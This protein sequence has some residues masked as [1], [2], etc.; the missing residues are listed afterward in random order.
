MGNSALSAEISLAVERLQGTEVSVLSPA[1]YRTASIAGYTLIGISLVLCLFPA[2]LFFALR[3]TKAGAA[4]LDF[5][6]LAYIA[7]LWLSQIG[8]KLA[9]RVP[10]SLMSGTMHVRC[11]NAYGPYLTRDVLVMSY[12]AHDCVVKARHSIGRKRRRLFRMCG[13]YLYCPTIVD[14]VAAPLPTPAKQ[15]AST[16][17][18]ARKTLFVTAVYSGGNRL[19]DAWSQLDW[20]TRTVSEARL[21]E[22]ER[23]TQLW[24]EAVYKFF[25]YERDRQP[26]AL[27]GVGALLHE[28]LTLVQQLA[29]TQEAPTENPGI[30]ASYREW[31]AVVA[32]VIIFWSGAVF[33]GSR[34]PAT[35]PTC[36]MT[37]LVGS[38]TAL[39]AGWNLHASRKR[40]E[41]PSTI[42]AP[43]TR[44]QGGSS[45]TDV[46]SR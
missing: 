40:S 12:Y 18:E 16:P 44:V 22:L 21:P 37:A 14:W 24:C 5:S 31:F 41:R 8:S 28:L 15:S 6:P 26:E 46:T 4:A 20:F 13:E 36:L 35:M 7:S 34:W 2:F 3:H 30:L 9:L 25:L 29:S 23:L 11:R 17:V 45:P 43:D 1:Q 38:G 39:L 33:I 19:A 10:R 27:D 42:S 32:V